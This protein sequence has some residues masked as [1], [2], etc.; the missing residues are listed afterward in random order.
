MRVFRLFRIAG[1]S[2]KIQLLLSALVESRNGILALLYALV[3]IVAFFSTLIYYAEQTGEYYQEGYWYYVED[4][5]IS[6][7]QSIPHTFWFTLVTLTTIGYGDV[8]PKTPLGKTAAS[9]AIVSSLFVIAFPLT[10]ITFQFSHLL[11]RW[12]ANQHAK[13]MRRK[14]MKLAEKDARK[15]LRLSGLHPKRAKKRFTELTQKALK[16][17]SLGSQEPVIEVTSADETSLVR[18]SK[19]VEMGNRFEDRGTNVSISNRASPVQPSQS[20]ETLHE[21]AALGHDTETSP[22][23]NPPETIN[24]ALAD[25]KTDANDPSVAMTSTAPKVAAVATTSNHSRLDSKKGLS[26]MRTAA[27]RG[28]PLPKVGA[29]EVPTIT[30]TALPQLLPTR[31]TPPQKDKEPPLALTTQRPQLI[32][33]R[34]SK[35]PNASLNGLVPHLFLFEKETVEP[36]PEVKEDS[37][38]EEH[39]TTISELVASAALGV[40][41]LSLYRESNSLDVDSQRPT[42]NPQNL[43]RV[44]V[45]ISGNSSVGS[46]KPNTSSDVPKVPSPSRRKHLQARHMSFSSKSSLGVIPAQGDAF[47][48][49]VVDSVDPIPQPSRHQSRHMSFISRSQGASDL[50]LRGDTLDASLPR[51]PFATRDLAC[52]NLPLQIPIPTLVGELGTR[53]PSHVEL[54]VCDFESWY[55]G[56][57]DIMSIKIAVRDQTQFVTFLRILMSFQVLE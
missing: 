21:D 34:S 1:K 46:N 18:D 8:T 17:I 4:N 9:L 54:K 47:P 55:S 53:T 11:R 49:D 23:L 52:Y 7:F 36:E 19:T 6:A 20:A 30:A 51:S 44:P 13:I 22:A 15:K 37:Q 12:E 42:E 5:S 43:L 16:Q 57:D 56:E 33:P 50:Y 39:L 45:K 14:H 35:L 38:P 2:G 40:P 41:V 32:A 25:E 48:G 31:G 3:T 10:M 24:L 27:T 29:D 28:T 26:F